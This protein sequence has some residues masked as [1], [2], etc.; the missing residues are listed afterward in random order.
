[1]IDRAY[2]R[3]CCPRCGHDVVKIFESASRP[4]LVTRTSSGPSTPVEDEPTRT[5]EVSTPVDDTIEL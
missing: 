3:V 5:F 4:P 1:M 2:V